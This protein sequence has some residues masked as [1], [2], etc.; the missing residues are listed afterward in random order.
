MWTRLAG[1]AHIIKQNAVIEYGYDE[2]VI[3][4]GT[5]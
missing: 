4:C 1:V 2:S 5:K 3:H